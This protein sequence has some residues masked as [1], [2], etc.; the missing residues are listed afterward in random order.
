MIL[1][2]VATFVALFWIDAPYGRFAPDKAT[3]WGP[4]LPA[5]WAWFIQESPSLLWM[6]FSW[7]QLSD[8]AHLA[9]TP[10]QILAALFCFHYVVRAWIF[11]FLLNQGKPVPLS[12]MLMAWM[13]CM[14]NGWMQGGYLFTAD[15]TRPAQ[16]AKDWLLQPRTQIGLALFVIGWAANQHADYTLRHL[17]DKKTDDKARKDGADS[18][19]GDSGSSSS[20]SA[21]VQHRYK[22]PH[23]GLF[24][25]VSA[26]NYT[27]EIIEWGGWALAANSWPATA[28]WIFTFC[29]LA[30]RA[31]S[32]H[33]WY[34]TH[35]PNYPKDR[36]AVIPFIW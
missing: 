14:Y 2:G 17:R 27:A 31:I 11:P 8:A 3:L 33:R 22:I 24:H 15:E 34:K 32:S 20:S 26:A 35:F 13:F 10:N 9:A 28:F 23:G 6:L 18:A 7:H 29:N 5:R 30:P 21:H 25:F 36:K 12:V 19:K 4:L 1:A 16:Y